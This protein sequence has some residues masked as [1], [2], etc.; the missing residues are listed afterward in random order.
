MF[1]P[2]RTGDSLETSSR[3]MRDYNIAHTGP[4]CAIL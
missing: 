1:E 3:S 2:Q 4:F